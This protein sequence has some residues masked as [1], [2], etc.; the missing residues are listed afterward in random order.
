MKKIEELQAEYKAVLEKAKTENRGLTADETKSLDTLKGEIEKLETAKANDNA[1]KAELEK[2]EEYLRSI[3]AAQ[4]T[5]KDNLGNADK[6]TYLRSI[7]K[8]S[9]DVGNK[10]IVND[11][12][13][14]FETQSP[15]FGAHQNI[16]RRSNGMA[17]SFTKVTKGGAGY[18]KTE[19]NAA[20]EDTASAAVPVSVAFKTYSGQKVVITQEALDD[21]AADIAQEIITLGSGKATTKF[22]AD[23]VAELESVDA[24]PT[25][26][27]ATSWALTDITGAFFEIPNRNRVG[28]KYICAPATA[29][30]IVN[31]MKA[32]D[33]AACAVV[34]LTAE[35]LIVDD[36]VT[37]DVLIVA[38]PTLALA[39]GMKEPV[40]VF[41]DEVSEGRA[42]EVQ[43]RMAVKLR[44]ST[45][46]ALR[47]LKAA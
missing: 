10:E 39:I 24:T 20:T 15:I 29:A 28:V 22:D 1:A 9:N 36:N 34:G 8:G 27:A 32:E 45:A 4:Q 35:N 33:A 14:Q 5:I 47:K 2:R 18:V 31:M 13:R 30:K 46:V 42:Y 19:G 23:A 26:T 12:V 17:F 21:F 44:D 7:T 43:P 16:Q 40:R 37:A 11:V 41:T 25:E 6:N 38:N 3:A